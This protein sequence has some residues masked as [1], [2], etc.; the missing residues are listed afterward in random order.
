MS[1][2]DEAKIKRWLN[3]TTDTARVKR[4]LVKIARDYILQCERYD[5]R[6]SKIRDDRGWAVLA[7]PTAQEDS[8][9]H[10]TTTLRKLWEYV[11]EAGYDKAFFDQAL[12][13]E[14]ELVEI[15]NWDGYC[16]MRR[17]DLKDVK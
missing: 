16:T 10:A 3:R 14:A 11:A 13:G 12:K 4:I 5:Q 9:R 2:E 8:R 15:M 7:T 1:P 17:P 6:L